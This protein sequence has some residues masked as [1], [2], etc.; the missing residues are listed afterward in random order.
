LGA[1]PQE[2]GLSAGKYPTALHFQI[3][4]SSGPLGHM[5]RGNGN[6]TMTFPQLSLPLDPLA[7]GRRGGHSVRVHIT[8]MGTYVPHKAT[9]FAA[10]CVRESF[11]KGNPVEQLAPLVSPRI[12]VGGMGSLRETFSSSRASGG[13]GSPLLPLSR[14]PRFPPHGVQ[15]GVHEF[16][17]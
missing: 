14:P 5:P 11:E 8:V 7:I 2:T 13:G 15:Q 6:R 16:V 9:L 1:S 4:C 12:P 3:L 17:P 10:P